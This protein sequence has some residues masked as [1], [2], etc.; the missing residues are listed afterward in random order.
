VGRRDAIA[1]VLTVLQ[2]SSYTMPLSVWQKKK[3]WKD[4]ICDLSRAILQ[5]SF[6]LADLHKLSR[7]GVCLWD[8]PLETSYMTTVRNARMA[9]RT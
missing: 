2:S 8:R 4:S 9:P 6:F 1:L 3:V 5:P 7:N